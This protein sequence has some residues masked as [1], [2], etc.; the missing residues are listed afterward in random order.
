MKIPTPTRHDEDCECR[1][2]DQ[3]WND[4]LLGYNRKNRGNDD[5]IT[6]W[7]D[8]RDADIDGETLEY[9]L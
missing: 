7:N 2:Y 4:Y 3:G 5:Y 8:A 9:M 1:F 6:G